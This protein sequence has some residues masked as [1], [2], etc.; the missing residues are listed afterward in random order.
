MENGF[1]PRTMALRLII[2]NVNEMLVEAGLSHQ[3][4]E[5]LPAALVK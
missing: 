2:A 4:G 5:Q 3:R 1:I